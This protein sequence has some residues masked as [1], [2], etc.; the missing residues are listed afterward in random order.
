MNLKMWV[1]PGCL[2]AA[3]FSGIAA[4]GA[5][6]ETISWKEEVALHDGKTIVVTR[7][8]T[9]GGVRREITQTNPGIS[10]YALDF[11][12]PNGKQVHWDNPGHLRPMILDFDEGIPYLATIPAMVKDYSDY[13]CPFPAYI[14]YKYQADW[15]R[16]AFKDFPAF[17][18]STNFVLN[19]EGHRAELT[20]R[21]VSTAEV[22]DMNGSLS[23][24]YKLVDPNRRSP[25]LCPTSNDDG[26]APSVQ[27]TKGARFDL[28]LRL[29]RQQSIRAWPV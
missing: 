18:R 23:K 8:V 22:A 10:N 3:L 4:C 5:Q 21:Q 26:H 11:T 7:S 20:N 12:A 28:F 17:F 6:T 25:D 24:H 9:L 15:Q 14:F 19:T 27:K 2:C 13:G 16:I 1:I 29:T